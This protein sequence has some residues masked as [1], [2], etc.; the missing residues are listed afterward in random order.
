MENLA[1]LKFSQP[2]T[3]Y[4]A[5]TELKALA[6]TAAIDIHE[7]AVVVCRDDR[8]LEARD[9]VGF[10]RADGTNVGSLLGL[11]IGIVGGPFGLLLGWLTGGAIGAA[12]DV[13]Q[14]ADAASALQWVGRTLSPG[15]TALIAILSEPTED[16]LNGMVQR[17]DGTVVRFSASAVQSELDALAEAEAAARAAADKAMRDAKSAARHAKWQ[18]VKAAALAKFGRTS[19]K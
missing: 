4:Q 17:L 10:D 2:A 14:A 7:A 3:S 5:F 11:V 15:E 16:A 18:E 9:T 19:S 1:I 6:G 8:T 13:S 12:V